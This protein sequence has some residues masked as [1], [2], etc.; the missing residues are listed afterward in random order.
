MLARAEV[1]FRLTDE[2]FWELSQDKWDDYCH[3]SDRFAIL[4]DKEFAKTRQMIYQ[5][6]SSKEAP[7]LDISEF[8]LLK[9]PSEPDPDDFFSAFEGMIP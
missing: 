7:N 4:M 2:E 8:R 1:E 6:F 5:S 3:V 9:D